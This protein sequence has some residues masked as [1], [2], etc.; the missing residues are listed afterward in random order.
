M[1]RA[2]EDII[3]G[4]AIVMVCVSFGVV[5]ADIIKQISSPP[6]YVY[7]CLPVINDAKEAVAVTPEEHC[8][9]RTI[10]YKVQ[11]K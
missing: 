9:T 5:L 6:R 10:L 1:K 4:G 7:F 11:L 8:S 3:I 2:I